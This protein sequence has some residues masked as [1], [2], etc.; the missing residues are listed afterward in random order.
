VA[1][2]LLSSVFL[3]IVRHPEGAGVAALLAEEEE[4]HQTEVE[5]EEVRRLQS[6]AE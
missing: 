5:G 2:L 1:R 3:N 4:L 6:T